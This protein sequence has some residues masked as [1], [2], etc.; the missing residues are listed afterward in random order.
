MA[1]LSLRLQVAKYNYAIRKQGIE[2]IGSSF[3]GFSKVAG[4]RRKSPPTWLVSA[5]YST[6]HFFPDGVF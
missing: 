1:G 2:Q 3:A 5:S 4:F 6:R